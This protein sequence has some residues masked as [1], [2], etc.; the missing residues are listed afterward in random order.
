VIVQ[1]PNF[2]CDKELFRKDFDEHE[3]VCEFRD[4]MCPKCG[5]KIFK[6]EEG[7]DIPHDCVEATQMHFKEM[8]TAIIKLR[9]Q[10]TQLEE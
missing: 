6:D 10:V 2:G 9:S 3:K 4:K 8:E 7:K 5:F 1:C